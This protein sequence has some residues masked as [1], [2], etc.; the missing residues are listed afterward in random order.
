MKTPT[1]MSPT[2]LNRG[3]FERETLSWLCG[4]V[5]HFHQLKPYWSSVLGPAVSISG[6]SLGG[7]DGHGSR[8]ASKFVAQNLQENILKSLGS[9]GLHEG[10]EEA[11]K[12]GYLRSSPNRGSVVVLAALLFSLKGGL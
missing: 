5:D 9:C 6:F 1:R 2:V 7:Y 4:K 3:F 8:K 11:I 12:D 10:K